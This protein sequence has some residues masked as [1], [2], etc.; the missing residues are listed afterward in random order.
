MKAFTEAERRG[1]L[2]AHQRVAYFI[3][4]VENVLRKRG[5]GNSEQVSESNKTIVPVAD[6]NTRITVVAAT[7]NKSP[8]RR[9]GALN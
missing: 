9:R 3:N 2:K 7:H 5:R 4:Q 6:P 8:N 1:P